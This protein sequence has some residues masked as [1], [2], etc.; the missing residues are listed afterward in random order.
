MGLT[1]VAELTVNARAIQLLFITYPL[2]NRK[3]LWDLCR[4]LAFNGEYFLQ[5]LINSWFCSIPD[6]RSFNQAD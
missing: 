4:V 1:R 6:A 5:R 3:R 2:T